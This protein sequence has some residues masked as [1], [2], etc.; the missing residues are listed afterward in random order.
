L[1]FIFAASARPT[2]SLSLWENGIQEWYRT[3]W[4][5]ILGSGTDD[6]PEASIAV[7]PLLNTYEAIKGLSAFKNRFFRF[8]YFI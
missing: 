6:P 4:N 5:R 1:V 7:V 8:F 2:A 3:A